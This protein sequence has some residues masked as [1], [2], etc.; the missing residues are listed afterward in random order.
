M[1]NTLHK[2]LRA[3]ALSI[4]D[5]GSTVNIE[6]LE[7]KLRVLQKQITILEHE[8]GKSKQGAIEEPLFEV[9]EPEIKVEESAAAIETASKKQ[10]ETPEVSEEP[11]QGVN[12][13]LEDLF[14]TAISEPVF[15][16]KED[17]APEE[18]VLE[19][20]PKNLNDVLGKGLKIGLND[21]LAFIKNLFDEH[22]EEYQR[23]IAQILVFENL[24]EAQEFIETFV[25]P[26]YNSWEGK[27]TYEERFYKIIEQNFN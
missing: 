17:P 6:E 14:T 18:E 8:Q 10:I 13:S 19:Q 27:E 26:E 24:E 20:N 22:P 23:V 3:I 25:K 11:S 2:E 1:I 7:E 21:R 12:E 4:L 5:Q 15:V 9:E 16:K